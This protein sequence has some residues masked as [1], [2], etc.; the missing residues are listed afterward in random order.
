MESAASSRRSAS[1]M[2]IS[3]RSTASRTARRTAS[4]CSVDCAASAL[5][6]VAATSPSRR[7]PP[8][9]S[10]VGS[11]GDDCAGTIA[12]DGGAAGAGGAG[13]A[14]GTSP[15]GEV[16]GEEGAEA[17]GA[18]ARPATRSPLTVVTS[19]CG[20]LS[21]EP[22]C[23]CRRAVF[24]NGWATWASP[25]TVWKARVA[26]GSSPPAVGRRSVRRTSPLAVW[27]RKGPSPVS[28]ASRRMSPLAVWMSKLS[29][30]TA[31]TIDVAAGGLRGEATARALD[32]QV[33]ARG[34][35]HEIPAGA[36]HPDVTRHGIERDLARRGRRSGHR[37]R[38][39]GCRPGRSSPGEPRS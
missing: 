28:M 19:M 14:G 9:V 15:A 25:E 24:R 22:T 33:A 16:G 4:S 39:C 6:L 17:L 23:Q 21:P 20:P 35:Q 37:R 29:V 3:P 30:W 18:A 7:G 11:V 13:G 26:A 31:V 10:G 27:A 34:L 32:G 1:S 8:M 38:R 36:H 12:G 2:S 5:T